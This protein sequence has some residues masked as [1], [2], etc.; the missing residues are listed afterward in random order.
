MI[1]KVLIVFIFLITSNILSQEKVLRIIDGD[2]FELFSG[3]IVR[4]I[5]INA[6][7]INDKY[8]NKSKEYLVNLIQAKDVILKSDSITKDKDI[9]GRLLRYVYLNNE[10][11][12]KKMI[13]NGYALVY[14]KYLFTK[15]E[16]YKEAEQLARNE[17]IGLW[18]D[19]KI[20][21]P[22][23]SNFKYFIIGTG[24]IILFV[25]LIYFLKK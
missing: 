4:L 16:E 11:I 3:E 7:E 9:Y 14:S 19:E 10:D 1:F 20:I 2:T 24:V 5:G 25:F 23:F 22:E 21:S 17:K 15:I 8:G 12:N 18:K 6:P 13:L